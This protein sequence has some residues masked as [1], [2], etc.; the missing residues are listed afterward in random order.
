MMKSKYVFAAAGRKVPVLLKATQQTQPA[1]T[2][3]L[4]CTA[5]ASRRDLVFPDRCRRL[6]GDWMDS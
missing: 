1:F 3:S 4:Y 6:C 5:A 2:A